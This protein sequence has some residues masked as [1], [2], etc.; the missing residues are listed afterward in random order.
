MLGVAFI[1]VKCQN[2][3]RPGRLRKILSYFEACLLTVAHAY[4]RYRHNLYCK[5]NMHFTQHVNVHMIVHSFSNTWDSYGYRF[6]YTWLLFLQYFLLK[7][8]LSYATKYA[9]IQE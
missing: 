5:S 4:N 3:Y 7:F 1:S 8:I 2:F 6:S 9:S